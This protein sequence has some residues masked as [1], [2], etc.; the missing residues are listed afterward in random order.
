MFFWSYIYLIST[1]MTCIPLFIAKL[2]VLCS[3]FLVCSEVYAIYFEQENIADQNI[4]V[5]LCRCFKLFYAVGYR[6][7]GLHNGIL[8]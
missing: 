8:R 2:S 7:K 5:L 3:V 4:L 1:E 6:A